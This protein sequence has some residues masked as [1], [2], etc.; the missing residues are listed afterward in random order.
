MIVLPEGVFLRR[1]FAGRM[2]E[3]SLRGSRGEPEKRLLFKSVEF[4]EG[5]NPLGGVG[6]GS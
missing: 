5:W 2:N 1:I 4:P 3:G 6:S